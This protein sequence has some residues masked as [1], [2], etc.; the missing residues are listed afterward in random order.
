VK[1]ALSFAV[2]LAA[3]ASAPRG[4]PPRV[5]TESSL[6]A[7]RVRPG[8]L[9]GWPVL[10]DVPGRALRLGAG[11]PTLV[12]A[13]LA[14]EN[15]WIGGFV[16]VPLDD[17][18]LAYARG[19]PT[20]NDVDVAIYSDDGAILAVDEERDA[21]PT[22]VL[23]PPHPQ[24]I[25]VAGHVAEGE[26]LVAVG[27]HLISQERAAGVSQGLGVHGTLEQRSMPADLGPGLDDA[28][29][30]HHIELGGQ[31]EEVRRL[32]LTVDAR[33]PA[34]LTVAIEANH[35][36][37]AFVLPGEDIGPLD[38]EVVDSDGRTLARSRDGSGPRGLIVCSPVARTGSLVIRPHI[39]RGVAAIVLARADAETYRDIAARPEVAWS[40]PRL[41]VQGARS[42]HET[43]LANGGYAGPLATVS[44]TLT[45]AARAIIPVA[46]RAPDG[47]CL[48]IDITAGEPLALVEAR[49]WSDAGALLASDEAPSS[50]LLFGCGGGGRARLELEARGRPGPFS[51]TVRPER[52]KDTAFDGVPLAASRMLAR[53]ALGPER[54]LQ[55]KERSVRVVLL[56][57]ANRVS[58]GE[59]VP[60][61]RCA[62]VSVGVQGEGAGVDL[63]VFDEANVELDRAEGPDAAQV[64]AC[65]SAGV[66]RLVHFEMRASAGN[67]KAVVGE[68]LD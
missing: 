24:R 20:V 17:C 41:S 57:A 13:G 7:P 51:V 45:L 23:C 54:V 14:V 8:E 48:R 63:R 62:R 11:A 34:Y 30:R 39:G 12:G 50:A 58:W 56:D 10:G 3:C 21:H 38:A 26:G 4:Q 67:L 16:E 47:A 18:V 53:A 5:G 42:V 60:A 37:D 55:G 2:L 19:G 1:V 32:A 6:S 66:G 9:D 31:W 25:Y 29:R 33:V 49:L 65:A 35:C 52:W 61:D 40:G 43:A 44:G 59:L 22:V 68:R 28:I 15:D 36:V 27:A 46:V 64:R